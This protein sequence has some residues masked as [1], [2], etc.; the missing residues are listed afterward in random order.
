MTE[1]GGDTCPTFRWPDDKRIALSLSFDDGRVS[2]VERCIPILDAYGVKGT[3]YVCP[4]NVHKRLDDWRAAALAGHEMGNHTL[5]HPCSGNNL[6]ARGNAL[7]EYTLDRIRQE[8]DGA[9]HELEEI[10]GVTPTT[11]AYPCGH[12]FVGRGAM[13]QSYVPLVSRGFTAGRGW[14]DFRHNTPDYCDLSHIYGVRFDQSCFDDVKQ[15]IDDA[16][17]E[18]GWL[19]LAG[20]DVGT[21]S[22]RQTVLEDTLHA[23]CQYATDSANG[24]WIDTVT[25]VADYIRQAR[26]D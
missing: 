18:N 4:G 2:Q 22:A 14:L 5:T 6:F 15:L 26:G 11:F 8:I 13:C 16:L 20:H 1:K 19:V 23:L 7:E 25:A 24:I 17:A 9:N 12:T 10:F 21:D 3:F